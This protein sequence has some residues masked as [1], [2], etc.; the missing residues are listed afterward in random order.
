MLIS[1]CGRSPIEEA[2]KDYTVFGLWLHEAC[3]SRP[4][5]VTYPSATAPNLGICTRQEFR[6]ACNHI[7]S[8]GA[9]FHTA[10]FLPR[11]SSEARKGLEYEAQHFYAENYPNVTYRGITTRILLEDG[12]RR[13]EPQSEQ[14]FYWPVHYLEPLE[15]NQ[16][17]I[18][19]DLYSTQREAVERATSTWLPVVSNRLTLLEESDE[20][21]YSVILYHPG[22][23]IHSEPNKTQ[24][25]ELALIVIRM[26]SL[27]SK[28]A[29]YVQ[30]HSFTVHVFDNQNADSPPKY[31]GGVGVVYEDGSMNLTQL[32]EKQVSELPE[33]HDTHHTERRMQVADRQWILA[34]ESVSGTF[35]PDILFVVIGG[36]I[37]LSATIMLA[38]WF[39]AHM[40]RMS[41]LTKMRA[42]AAAEKAALI[43][44]TARKQA[45][46]ERQLNEYIAHV[47]QT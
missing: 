4:T 9:D 14:P 21:A 32:P 44:D 6:D 17:A 8:T 19:L 25:S 46:M 27:L 37:I 28:C 33:F 23:P 7:F 47:S 10:E 24:P 36:M 40:N 29:S 42:D 43:V 1:T 13:I 35:V 39:H 22:I 38:F 45:N 41:K 5:K 20:D 18:E 2:L 11:V 3:R 31:L 26:P 15:G 34:I 12:E 16:A 30:D